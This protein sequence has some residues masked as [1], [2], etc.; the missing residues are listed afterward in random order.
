MRKVSFETSRGLMRGVIK[1]D[2]PEEKIWPFYS[3]HGGKEFS[4]KL[5]WLD[6]QSEDLL[7]TMFDHTRVVLRPDGWVSVMLNDD[8]YGNPEY[9]AT[10]ES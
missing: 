4:C 7:W 1:D 10:I 3:C 6:E 8:Y 5:V 2:V 9:K